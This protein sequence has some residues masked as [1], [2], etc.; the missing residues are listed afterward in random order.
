MAIVINDIIRKNFPSIDSDII[1][2]L[3]SVFDNAKDDFES[4]E[5]VFESVGEILMDVCQ[6]EMNEDE[7]RKICQQIFDQIVG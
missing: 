7:V 1:S 2:Y 4:T 5:E 3:D 6:G